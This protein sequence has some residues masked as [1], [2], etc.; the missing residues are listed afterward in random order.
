[1][2]GER[3]LMGVDLDTDF[4]T[5]AEPPRCREAPSGGVRGELEAGGWQV[6]L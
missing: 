3:A 6:E 1:M 4:S 5:V 2:D